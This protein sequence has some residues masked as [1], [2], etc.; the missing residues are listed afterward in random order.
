M[1]T[2]YSQLYNRK[3]SD[4][5]VS[6]QLLSAGARSC[7]GQNL[8]HSGRALSS[9]PACSC[10]ATLAAV[11]VN[12]CCT[13]RKLSSKPACSSK[14]TDRR[15]CCRSLGQT[16]GQTDEYGVRRL[17]AGKNIC[18]V[19]TYVDA[20]CDYADARVLAQHDDGGHESQVES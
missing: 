2:L 4:S 5:Y 9:K 1:F 15:R 20:G 8:L 12:I 16:D 17:A 13:G 14:P 10:S 3:C 6:C 18:E 19:M 7:V 11:S